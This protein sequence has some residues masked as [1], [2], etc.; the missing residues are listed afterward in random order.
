MNNCTLPAN[1]GQIEI[2]RAI[3][4]KIEELTTLVDLKEVKV[5]IPESLKH[6]TEAGNSIVNNTTNTYIYYN[7]QQKQIPKPVYKPKPLPLPLH[8]YYRK[9]TLKLNFLNGYII[10]TW[11]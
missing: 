7:E 11:I 9:P 2:L 5:E 3:Y 1:A 10:D 8:Y 6:I 4:A